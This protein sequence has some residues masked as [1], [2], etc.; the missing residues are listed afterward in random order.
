ELCAEPFIEADARSIPVEHRPLHP[1]AAV[2]HGDLRERP[3]Q[4][5][6]RAVTAF[7]GED[8]EVLEVERRPAHE[9]GIGEVVERQADGRAAPSA[10][11]RLEVA[12]PAEAVPP[13]PP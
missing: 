11:E 13:D 4:R 3:E 5:P 9:R 2:P 7:R 12:P 10:D 8:E 1:A 6:A